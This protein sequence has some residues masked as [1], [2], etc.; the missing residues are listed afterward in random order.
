MPISKFSKNDSDI[1]NIGS[2]LI[3]YK[4]KKKIGEIRDLKQ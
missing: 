3:F 4:N 2:K 1:K